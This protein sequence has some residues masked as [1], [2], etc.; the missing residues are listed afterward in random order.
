MEESNN[1]ISKKDIIVIVLS[2]VALMVLVVIIYYARKNDQTATMELKEQSINEIQTNSDKVE[3]DEGVI[4]SGLL[5]T[6][7]NADKWIEFYNNSNADYD[8]TGFTLYISGK[9]VA[10]FKEGTSVSKNSF[11]AADIE[12]NPGEKKNNVITLK[13]EN[14]NDVISVIVPKLLENQS[15]GRRTKDSNDVGYVTASKGIEN[16][17]PSDF[18]MLTYDGIGVSS[19]SGFYNTAFDLTLEA[20]EGESIFYTL[21]GTKP[22][23]SST[24]Y[25]APIHIT[26][27][28]GSNYVYST[29]A[30]E[31]ERGTDYHPGSIDMGVVLRAIKV[32][33]K[34]QI[35][36]ETKQTYY[37]GLLRKSDYQKLPVISITAEPD[38]LFGYFDGIYVSGRSKDDGLATGQEGTGN[39]L[40][41]WK[42][43]AKIE[44]FESG[45]GKTFEAPVQISIGIG[46]GKSLR[47]KGFMFDISSEDAKAYE[48]SSINDYITVRNY[49]DLNANQADNDLK[50]REFVINELVE[51]ADVGNLNSR[52]CIVFINGEYWGVYTL[53]DCLD[54]KY[55]ERNYG[56]TSK[57]DIYNAND[58]SE[59]YENFYNFV[60]Q[61][62]MSL[63]ENYEDFKSMA[64]IDSYLQYMCV[65]IFV[66]NYRFNTKSGIAW[67]TSEKGSGK[68]EDG[69]WRWVIRNLDITMGINDLTSYRLDTFLTAEIANDAFFNSLLMNKEFCNSLTK[70]MDDVAQN[71]FN[72]DRY[73]Q[74][75]GTYSDLLKKPVVASRMRFYGGY[76]ENSFNYGVGS[77]ENYLQNRYEYISVYT[78]EIAEKGGDMAVVQ[79]AR[80]SLSQV[81]QEGLE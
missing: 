36:G 44:F 13:D 54:E 66:G 20:L 59:I 23:I 4:Q 32:D 76:D 28:S 50:M 35:T 17:N 67:K 46:D 19:P 9:K 58:F 37:I 42:R 12:V 30:F 48:G 71:Y 2:A 39:Y 24:K 11:Y 22:T 38:D 26:N 15:F 33:S 51:G 16:E 41:G 55:I 49:I 65:N 75:I 45:K 10:E 5:F 63:K 6:E 72:K 60:V 29:M 7:A 64:D 68:Y 1:R 18:Q 40:N 81:A 8:L 69:K 73:S 78:K 52:P 80:D 74:V 43:D 3:K 47:Q 61:N 77:I 79:V 70:T 57:V 53:G 21:D 56:V 25:E 31:Y 14:D 27:M 34:G 62:D